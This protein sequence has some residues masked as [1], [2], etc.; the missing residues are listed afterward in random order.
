MTIYTIYIVAVKQSRFGEHHSINGGW[1]PIRLTFVLCQTKITAL[2]HVL[3]RSKQ[4]KTHDSCFGIPRTQAVER[5]KM[6]GPSNIDCQSP[7]H[8]HSLSSNSLEHLDCSSVCSEESQ[9]SKF[10]QTCWFTN[11]NKTRKHSPSSA[12]ASGLN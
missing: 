4:L 3:P 12:N 11:S 1:N 2:P 10:T 7:K 8:Q 9:S 6:G 5:A